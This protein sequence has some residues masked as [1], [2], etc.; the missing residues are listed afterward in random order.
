MRRVEQSAGKSVS[1]ARSAE[2]TP[3]VLLHD[4]DVLRNHVSVLGSHVKLRRLAVSPVQVA[5]ASVGTAP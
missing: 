4:T 5:P 1:G 2:E 3:G